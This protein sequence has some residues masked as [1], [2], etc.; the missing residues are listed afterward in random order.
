VPNT[1]EVN[2][3]STIASSAGIRS[4]ASQTWSFAPDRADRVK[5]IAQA[6]SF[7][8]CSGHGLG[9]CTFSL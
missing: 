9:R 4:P 1:D 2:H 7:D 6:R 3:N 8:F 5:K